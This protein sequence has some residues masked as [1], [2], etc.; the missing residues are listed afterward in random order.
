MNDGFKWNVVS[1]M[2]TC[3]FRAELTEIECDLIVFKGPWR[4]RRA[5]AMYDAGKGFEKMLRRMG[6]AYV[7]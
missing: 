3:K 4:K 7:D 2:K 1:S 6:Y 5:E